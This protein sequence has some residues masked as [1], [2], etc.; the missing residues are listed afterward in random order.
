VYDHPR[1]LIFRKVPPAAGEGAYSRERVEALLG[2]ID[3]TQAQNG[4]TPQEAS[5]A[6]TRVTLAPIICPGLVLLTLAGWAGYRRLR[7]TGR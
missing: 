2:E 4:L 3:V 6:A 7:Q 1:V 5:P